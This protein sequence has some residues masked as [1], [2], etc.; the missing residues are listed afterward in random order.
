MDIKHV[1]SLNPLR[2]GLCAAPRPPRADAVAA[3]RFRRRSTGGLAR[4][5]P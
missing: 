3:A 4:D 5:R 2:P 1:L